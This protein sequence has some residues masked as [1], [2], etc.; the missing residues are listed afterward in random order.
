MKCSILVSV[1][2]SIVCGMLLVV[3]IVFMMSLNIRLIMN[4][5]KKKCDM[6]LVV[7]FSVCM[8][9]FILVSLVRW[10]RC[11]CRDFCFSRMNIS[12]ISMMLVWL[13]GF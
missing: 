2:Y 4:C 7:L 8:V 10:I 1:F 5:E 9:W 6:F 3:S 11:L 13:I 12:S